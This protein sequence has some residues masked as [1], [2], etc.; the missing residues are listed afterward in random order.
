MTKDEVDMVREFF[1]QEI[2]GNDVQQ[3]MKIYK[4]LTR[5]IKDENLGQILTT[6]I[7]K[8]KGNN[9]DFFLEFVACSVKTNIKK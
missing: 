7:T 8:H 9:F 1:D 2:R 4:M 6:A 5:G 3:V